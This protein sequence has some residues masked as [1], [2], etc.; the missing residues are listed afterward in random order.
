MPDDRLDDHLGAQRVCDEALGVRPLDHPPDPVQ[1]A[2]GPDGEFKMGPI[3]LEGPLATKGLVFTVKASY[4]DTAE[5][6]TVVSV[7]GDRS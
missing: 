5:Q 6:G 7:F 1:I 3:P 2:A 4:P